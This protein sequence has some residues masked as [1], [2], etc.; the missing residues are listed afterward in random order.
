MSISRATNVKQTGTPG[1]Y[2]GTTALEA[3][4]ALGAR[5]IENSPGVPRSGLLNPTADNIVIAATGWSYDILACNPIINRTANEGVYD[6]VLYG[7][8]NITTG[9]APGAGTSR[10]DLIWVKQSDVDKGDANNLP[11]VGVTQGSAA[12]SP[13]KPAAPTGV[14][15]LAEAHIFSGTTSTGNGAN[16]ITQVWRY[17]GLRGTVLNIRNIAERNEITLPYRGMRVRRLDRDDWIQD[18]D[19]VSWHF[20]GKRRAD[21]AVTSFLTSS[22]ASRQVLLMNFTKPYP[23]LCDV[24]GALTVFCPAIS[25]GMEEINIAVSG[26]QTQVANAQ[27]RHRLTWTA[28]FNNCNASGAGRVMD[29][30]LAT[31]A[32]LVARVWIEVLTGALS[33]SPSGGSYAYLVVD[34]IPQDD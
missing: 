15:V 34:Y 12:A 6:P 17:A 11:S 9:T 30:A 33:L 16:T 28:G 1:A 18:Y 4:R 5:F 10:W 2:V 31:S 14:L 13:T 29:Y 19:G 25:T 8:T 24:Y 26:G 7:T 22:A 20:R 3:R 27:A 32:D 21:N 23:T